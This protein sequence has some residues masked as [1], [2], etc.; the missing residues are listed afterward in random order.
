LCDLGT[1]IA[2]WSGMKNESW[3]RGFIP[4]SEVGGTAFAAINGSTSCRE[5]L[6]SIDWI[7]PQR[8]PTSC[9]AKHG[10]AYGPLNFGIRAY[11]AGGSVPGLE[12]AHISMLPR[13]VVLGRMAGG[14]SFCPGLDFLRTFDPNIHL[15]KFL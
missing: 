7:Q 3:F 1:R 5:I 14:I 13:G 12:K 6:G 8:S 15:E 10:T 4:N 11:L 9:A 2:I